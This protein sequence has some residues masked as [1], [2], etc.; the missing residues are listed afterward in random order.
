MGGWVGGEGVGE[1][2]LV[3]FQAWSAYI[4]MEGQP[5]V[6]PTLAYCLVGWIVITT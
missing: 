4:S 5:H 3:S 6:E 2:L 1:G